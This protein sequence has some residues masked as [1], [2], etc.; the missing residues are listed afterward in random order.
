MTLRLGFVGVG[1]W[2]R[3]LAESFRACG[4]EIVAHDRR[5]GTIFDD[6]CPPC[7]GGQ[8]H[9]PDWMHDC[10]KSGFGRRVPWRDQLADKSIDAIV[11][12]APPEVTTQVALACAE[13]GKAVMATKPL[14]DHPA[15][16]RAPFYVDFWRLWANAHLETK[17]QRR[18]DL[19]GSGPLRAFPGAFDYGP[20]VMAAILD[21][22][23]RRRLAES[24]RMQSD[25]GGELFSYTFRDM[26]TGLFTAG[27]FGN[28]A[29]ESQ[30][31]VWGHEETPTHIGNQLKSDVMKA[32]CSSFIADVQEGFV[33][34]KLLNYSREGMR[35][36]RQIREM[37]K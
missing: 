36:L 4:A 14:F 27:I 3:K 29:P 12:V 26:E 7:L 25:N 20:H 15:T 37:A 34:T 35:L 10:E 11:A 17:D 6:G 30:R 1:R 2:A 18:Y 31:N 5:G 22:F 23:P 33:D 8:P 28:G 32:F 13:A 19:F 16:I 9:L 24:V 21:K